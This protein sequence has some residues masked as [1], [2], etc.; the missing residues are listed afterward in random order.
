MKK[1]MTLCL[2]FALAYA[3][4]ATNE[5]KICTEL[6]IRLSRYI[7]VLPMMYIMH[8]N[9]DEFKNFVPGTGIYPLKMEKNSSEVLSNKDCKALNEIKYMDQNKAYCNCDIFN[10]DNNLAC[11][12]VSYGNNGGKNGAFIEIS[13]INEDNEICKKILNNKFFKEYFVYEFKKYNESEFF[14]MLKENLKDNPYTRGTM[15]IL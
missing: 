1:I 4:S 12:K 7:N 9:F 3:N 10:D 13:K 11:V 6:G 15:T 8:K 5:D 2:M 14:K